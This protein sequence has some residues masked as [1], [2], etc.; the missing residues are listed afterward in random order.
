MLACPAVENLE[1]LGVLFI[2]GK[3]PV[4][5][6]VANKYCFSYLKFEHICQNSS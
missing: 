1:S 4:L 6:V 5:L 2:L 3:N